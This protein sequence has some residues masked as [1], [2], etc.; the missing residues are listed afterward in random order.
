MRPRV[1]TPVKP[2][3][4]KKKKKKRKEVGIRTK[5]GPS[6]LASEEEPSV[7]SQ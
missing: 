3:N 5:P 4:T 1:Q 7:H 6:E 2:N